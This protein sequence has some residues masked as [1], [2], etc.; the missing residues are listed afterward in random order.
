VITGVPYGGYTFSHWS[1]DI[2]NTQQNPATVNM[3]RPRIITANFKLLYDI[4]PQWEQKIDYT[5]WG[6]AQFHSTVVFNN[7]IWVLGGYNNYFRSNAIWYSSD[8]VNWS[9]ATTSNAWTPRISHSTV[10]FNN[11][12]W[13]LGGYDATGYLNDVWSSS[14][15]TNWSC[16]LTNA[17]WSKRYSFG[18]LV[19]DG[20]IWVFGGKGISGWL[21]DV[22]YSADGINWT[23]ATSAAA[24]QPREG[25]GACVFDNKM[26][27]IGGYQGPINSA[28]DVWYS[29]NG[30]NWSS[31]TTNAN[32]APRYQH[33]TVVFDNRIWMLGG[34]VR[35][36][37]G[38]WLNATN[39]V[40]YS[41]DGVNWSPF[42]NANWQPRYGHTSFV[43]SDKIW[44]LGGSYSDIWAGSI[45]P[46]PAGTLRLTVG[47]SSREAGT[48]I[49]SPGYYYDTS[50][51][52]FHLKAIP[53]YGYEFVNWT[54]D[55]ANPNTEETTVTLTSNKTVVANFVK[56][57]TYN[58]TMG[59]SPSNSGSIIPLPGNHSYPEGTIVEIVAS[60]SEGY[61]FSHWTG[62]VANPVS[63]ST[64]VLVD[65]NKTIT[66]NF[67]PDLFTPNVRIDGGQAHT[68]MLLNEGTV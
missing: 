39:E 41:M 56:K 59:I 49:P 65:S 32:W 16:V 45:P 24:W 52:V 19:Y 30:T 42:D 17:P 58:L 33:T 31:A 2:E 36:N 64:T 62:D 4:S 50:G 57:N 21:N 37:N 35:D 11:K 7:N 34:I 25:H 68:V 48:T 10:V 53:S 20:K 15:G 63:Q 29:T 26:W 61:V 3:D 66:A 5:P 23:Q 55:V 14:D 22:W 67:T 27:V 18:A 40:W 51:K 6:S 46:P 8:G 43:F 54:G 12:I 44:V 28:S 13:V 47:T 38:N 9:Q 1:G 60:P